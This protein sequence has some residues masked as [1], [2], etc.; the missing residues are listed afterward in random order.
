MGEGLR[1]YPAA[2]EAIIQPTRRAKLQSVC[3]RFRGLTAYDYTN[4]DKEGKPTKV[5]LS[6]MVRY[7]INGPALSVL[8]DWLDA[9][10]TIKGKVKDAMREQC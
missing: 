1:E 2:L 7:G 5:K 4:V 6:D 10:Q 3:D 8:N 9:T